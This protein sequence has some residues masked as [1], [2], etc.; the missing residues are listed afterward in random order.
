MP[1]ALFLDGRG[2]T[3]LPQSLRAD[4]AL[5]HLDARSNRLTTLPA[6]LADRN[7]LTALPP[8]LDRLTKLRELHLRDNR[9][10]AMPDAIRAAARSRTPARARPR[11]PRLAPLP[12]RGADRR[13]RL[14]V[15]G[16]I[17][18]GRRYAALRGGFVGGAWALS[19]HPASP[20]ACRFGS[21]TT[22][23]RRA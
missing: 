5:H 3:E 18:C 23:P 11:R 17:V 22:L 14:P 21:G 7:S 19:S 20:E 1:Q 9:I 13:G 2:M 4:A 8:A 16:V 10:A 12:R 15:V 6:W